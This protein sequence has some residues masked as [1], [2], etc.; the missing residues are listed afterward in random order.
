MSN[1]SVTNRAYAGER[2]DQMLARVETYK[3]QV[4]AIPANRL[5][6]I[7]IGTN[8]YRQIVL[9]RNPNVESDT[10]TVVNNIVASI[11]KV[12]D[13]GCRRIL[14]VNLP[15]LSLFPEFRG[16]IYESR[17]APLVKRHN[18]KLAQVLPGL[19]L[20]LNSKIDLHEASRLFDMIRL[21]PNEF[22]FTEID[23]RCYYGGYTVCGSPETTLFFDFI[24]LNSRWN[25]L[26]AEKVA[27]QIDP[28]FAPAPEQWILW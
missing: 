5:C 6:L 21:R 22:G 3:F 11:R 27:H 23:A 19:A 8:D 2:S 20:E 26:L 1:R 14:V 4:G 25:Q 13:A 17:M 12:H 9:A 18:E 16:Q 24:H 7:F 15:D 10:T 28:W